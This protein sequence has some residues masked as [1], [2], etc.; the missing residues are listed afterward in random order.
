MGWRAGWQA[1]FFSLVNSR[2]FNWGVA[3][4]DVSFPTSHFLL[5]AC[6]GGGGQGG[7]MWAHGLRPT[8]VGVI[9]SIS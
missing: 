1:A 4:V 8:A 6:G 9:L 2:S 7:V 5:A 3:P